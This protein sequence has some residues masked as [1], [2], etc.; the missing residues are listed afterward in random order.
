MMQVVHFVVP[1]RNVEHAVDPIEPRVLENLA[2][3][4]H[5]HLLLHL[6]ELRVKQGHARNNMVID[7]WY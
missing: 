2:L 6:I 4:N 7:E 1:I 3:D 5:Q